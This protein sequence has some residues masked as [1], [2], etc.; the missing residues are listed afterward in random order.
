MA[1]NAYPGCN[2]KKVIQNEQREGALFKVIMSSYLTR[3]RLNLLR[4]EGQRI[5]SYS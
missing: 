4:D 1:K 5:I 3:C 2:F